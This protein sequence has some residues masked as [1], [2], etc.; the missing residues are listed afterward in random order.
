MILKLNLKKKKINFFCSKL[1]ENERKKLYSDLDLN[2]ITDNKQF[3]KTIK[4]LLS[5][6]CLQTSTISLADNKDVISDDSELANTI[7]SFVKTRKQSGIKEYENF[8]K[9]PDSRSQNNVD[10][11]VNKNNKI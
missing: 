7:N 11:A 2:K 8:D 5:E 1:Y 3:W 10:M 6:K 4:T 9:N